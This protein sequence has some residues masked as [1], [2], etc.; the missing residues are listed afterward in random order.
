[1]FAAITQTLLQNLLKVK[2]NSASF[3]FDFQELRIAHIP[4]YIYVCIHI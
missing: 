1:M 2:E 3:G 4:T